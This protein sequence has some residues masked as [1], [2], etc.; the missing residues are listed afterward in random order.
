MSKLNYSK[1]GFIGLGIMGKPMAKNLINAGFSLIVHN[2]SQSPADELATLGARVANSPAEVAQL[3]S[4]VI[5]MLPNSP[6]VEQVAL[7]KNG[8]IEGASEGAV[9]ID[10]SSIAPLVSQKIA[11][12]LEARGIDFLDAPVSGGEIGAIQGTLAIMVGGKE[13]IFQRCHPIFQ[14]LG[15]SIVHLGPVGA[16]GIA[17]LANQ[18]IVALNIA[19]VGEAFALASKA[20]LDLEKLFQAIRG[21]LAGSQVMEAKI[22]KI[23]QRNFAPGFK[24]KLHQ[25]D[26]ANVLATAAGLQVPLPLTGMVAQILS[27]LMADEKGEL[28]HGAIIQ[29]VEKLAHVEI[30]RGN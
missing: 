26:I 2:R 17:K 3:S 8:I 30:Q 18:I 29:F 5:T 7:G 22:P 10:M 4:V 9:M 14:A 24:I 13:E 15:K 19:A 6:D 11:R 1:L 20:G 12:E 25:K 16:G 27:A 23:L 28:D 21:G